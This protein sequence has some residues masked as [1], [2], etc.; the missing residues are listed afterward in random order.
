MG[1]TQGAFRRAKR[2]PCICAS[3]RFTAAYGEASAASSDGTPRPLSSPPAALDPST[4][5][6]HSDKRRRLL[7]ATPD[8]NDSSSALSGGGD[9]RFHG[10]D[11]VALRRPLLRLI[12]LPSACGKREKK[13]QDCRP[14]HPK[15]PKRRSAIPHQRTPLAPRSPPRSPSPHVPADAAR[16]P[17]SS[18]GPDRGD[19]DPRRW[20]HSAVALSTASSRFGPL[21]GSCLLCD[22]D[23]ARV[24]SIC[25]ATLAPISRRATTTS[26]AG[27]RIV[28]TDS[29]APGRACAC[30][31]RRRRSATSP[32]ATASR[33]AT[34]I[35]RRRGPV[36]LR[37]GGLLAAAAAAAADGGLR[38]GQLQGAVLLGLEEHEPARLHG[39]GLLLGVEPERGLQRLDHREPGLGPEHPEAG[40]L[41]R[42]RVRLLLSVADDLQ[43][44]DRGAP[45]LRLPGHH[46]AAVSAAAMLLRSV[47][48]A[49][50]AAAKVQPA[51]GAM[52]L[53][54]DPGDQLSAWVECDRRA[55]SVWHEQVVVQEVLPEAAAADVQP[56]RQ[57][58][59]VA[60]R[61]REQ[62]QP[63]IA[64]A[65]NAGSDREQQRQ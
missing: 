24:R 33:S 19:L 4:S 51:D 34:R 42:Q 39:A 8:S 22:G 60:G 58:A 16:I 15:P 37:A 11:A 64:V 6:E 21:R 14:Q 59:V 12:A 47:L 3:R 57:P 23:T 43:R 52:V 29:A 32:R 9:A 20:I 10:I 53:L 30:R 28:S 45:E 36:V 56:I 40:E 49:A 46:R 7:S 27:R 41:V 63:A 54:Q 26:A 5:G 2:S 50:G 31:T 35:S 25:A 48:P 61:D 18:N 44:D 38:C 62:Q 55:G 1:G 13:R 65:A 17:E